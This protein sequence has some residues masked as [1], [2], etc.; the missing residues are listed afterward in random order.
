MDAPRG[1][2]QTTSGPAEAPVKVGPNAT[3]PGPLGKPVAIVLASALALAAVAWAGVEF[4]G[5]VQDTDAQGTPGAQP[6]VTERAPAEPASTPSPEA[7]APS[8]SDPANSAPV[9]TDPTPPSGTGGE[10]QR[11]T[12]DGTQLA[13]APQQ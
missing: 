1:N 12:P 2:S 8:Q 6:S 7:S 5:E 10:S 3:R 9:E 11:V 4:W 13:P